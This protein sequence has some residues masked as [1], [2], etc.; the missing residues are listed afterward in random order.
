MDEHLTI[1]QVSQRT[2]VATSALRFYEERNLIA[3]ERTEGNQRRYQR[4]VLRTVSVIKAAQE[5]GLSLKE[6]S[7]ALDSLPEGR[8]PTKSDWA[9]LAT[10]WRSD[11]DARIAEL[12]ALRNDLGDCIG[13]GCL[14]LTACALFN[15]QDQAAAAGTGARY[16]VGDTRPRPADGREGR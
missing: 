1:G 6:I 5:V 7:R 11:L 12:E 9:K 14:S 15:P 13:C 2:G 10:G 16:I 8:T 3:S 4:S